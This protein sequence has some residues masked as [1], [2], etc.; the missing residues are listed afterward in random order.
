MQVTGPDGGFID[1]NF[2]ESWTGGSFTSE[3]IATQKVGDIYKIAVEETVTFGESTDI[4]YQVYTLDANAKI[5]W[6][7]VAFRTSA[8]LNEDEFGQDLN[9]DGSI[10]QGSSSSASDTYTNFDQHC[11][12]YAAVEAEYGNTA[13][14]PIIGIA[15]S[16]SDSTDTEIEMFSGGVEGRSK[17]TY[18]LDVGIIQEA[19]DAV[20]AKVGND[21]G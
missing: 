21:T 7:N 16:Q 9:A 15:N 19:N 13:Q 2:S 20:L 3:A 5:D 1:L 12:C 4:S 6:N 8:E 14:S 17:S 18:Q 11:K 10:S